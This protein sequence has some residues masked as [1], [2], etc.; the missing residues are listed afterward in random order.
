MNR[1]RKLRKEHKLSQQALAKMLGVNQTAVSQWERGITAPSAGLLTQLCEI[2]NTSSD[3]LLGISDEREIFSWSDSE[4]MDAV[5][6]NLNA[7][8]KS[9]SVTA[10]NDDDQIQ[11]LA[12]DIMVELFH[13]LKIKDARQ[14][15]SMLSFLQTSFSASTRFADVCS[16]STNTQGFEGDRITKA[17]DSAVSTYSDA[18]SNLQ[19]AI[20]K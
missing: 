17:R 9:I 16:A 14:R 19:H 4:I 1:L 11:K 15:A 10:S 8:C 7:L 5:H 3:Y 2:L 13:A 12:F 20:L 6:D 18:L